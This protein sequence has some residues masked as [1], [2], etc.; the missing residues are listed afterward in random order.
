MSLALFSVKNQYY[1]N[2]IWWFTK[3]LN[4]AVGENRYD[5]FR[6]YRRVLTNKFYF[7]RQE[8]LYKM[9]VETP[10]IACMLGVYPKVDCS[11][12]FG[13]HSKRIHI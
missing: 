11:H 13:Y 9:F 7:A 2:G 5:A 8:W 10:D 6:V 1:K 3:M 4:R 12:G